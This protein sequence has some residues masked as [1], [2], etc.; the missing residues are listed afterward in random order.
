[1]PVKLGA[2]AP[3]LSAADAGTAKRQMHATA[4]TVRNPFMMATPFFHD[5]RSNPKIV[6]IV[7]Q[8]PPNASGICAPV[9][10]VLGSVFETE[11]KAAPALNSCRSGRPPKPGSPDHGCAAGLISEDFHPPASRAKLGHR[12]TP[13]CTSCTMAFPGPAVAARSARGSTSRAKRSGTDLAPRSPIF[14]ASIF[15]R[16]QQAIENLPCA[17]WV[18]APIRAALVPAS[19]P[20]WF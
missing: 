11:R 14:R 7:E 10:T 4:K 13:Y 16:V 19:S 9:I 12:Q 1:M 15:A 20:M 5:F 3:T 8:S 18:L 6:K 2:M 17:I